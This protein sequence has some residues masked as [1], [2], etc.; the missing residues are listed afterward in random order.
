MDEALEVEGVA[1]RVAV[2][3]ASPQIRPSRPWRRRTVGHVALS[4]PLKA[5]LQLLAEGKGCVEIAA[6]L[7]KDKSTI[8]RQTKQLCEKLGVNNPEEALEKA[9][10]TGLV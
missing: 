7:G 3:G 5:I 6:A 2:W 1:E 8:S 4:A 10:R 9:R